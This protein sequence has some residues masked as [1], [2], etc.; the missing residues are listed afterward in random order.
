MVPVTVSDWVTGRGDPQL[1][2]SA[3]VPDDGEAASPFGGG[4]TRQWT[5]VGS[6]PAGAAPI[7]TA[8]VCPVVTDSAPLGSENPTA[9][10]CP[11]PYDGGLSDDDDAH[12]GS[13]LDASV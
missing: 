1:G 13:G 6:A 11:L 10:S 2:A 4:A 3:S 8:V 12:V 7:S 9:G 5:V